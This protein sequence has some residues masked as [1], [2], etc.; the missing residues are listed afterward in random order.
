MTYTF[1]KTLHVFGVILLF[2][3]LGAYAHHNAMGGTKESNTRRAVTAASH[4]IALLILLVAGFGAAGKGGMMSNGFPLW[5]IAKLILWLF[6]GGAVAI[7]SKKP[8][9]GSV[10]WWVLPLLGGVA[11]YLAIYKPF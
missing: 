8:G 6:F 11:A 4:G 5:L 3:S 1:Y 10:L 7:L 9:V 2:T